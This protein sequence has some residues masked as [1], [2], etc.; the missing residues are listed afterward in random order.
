MS[1]ITDDVDHVK[2][3]GM[4]TESWKHF[5]KHMKELTLAATVRVEYGEA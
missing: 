1:L 5:T 2:L 3:Y 4:F